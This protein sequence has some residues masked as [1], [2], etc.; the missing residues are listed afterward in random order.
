[1]LFLSFTFLASFWVEINL[2]FQ[3]CKSHLHS[4]PKDLSLAAWFP[5]APSQ[6][7]AQDP[8]EERVSLG[9]EGVWLK[10][11]KDEGFAYLSI[12]VIKAHPFLSCRSYSSLK[13]C[14]DRTCYSTELFKKPKCLWLGLTSLPH[15]HCEQQ[16]H[17]G[18]DCQ[19][20]GC[21]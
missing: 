12:L 10:V 17:P 15:S 6:D 21:A 8:D 4:V 11:S 7:N 2:S 13:N 18:A 19:E 20:K 9:N 3:V 14:S 1:M 5:C 16:T